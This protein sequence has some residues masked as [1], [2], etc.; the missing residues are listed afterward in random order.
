ME[1]IKIENRDGKETV[2]ARELF[3]F[4]GFDKSQWARW[5]KNNIEDDDFFKQG[6]DWEGF[7]TVLNGNK[8]KDYSITL[9]MAKELS[10]LARNAKG[11][12]ARRYF[13]EVEKKARA[14][15]TAVDETKSKEARKG[16]T[17]MWK[18][19]GII[20]EYGP[21]TNIEYNA[22]GFPKGTKKANM[23]EKQKAFLLISDTWESLRLSME[24]SPLGFS[25]CATSLTHTCLEVR[26]QARRLGLDTPQNLPHNTTPGDPN[27][28][29]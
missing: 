12:E 24:S 25:G 27:Q 4:L 8:T 16:L 22:L 14:Y 23:D 17:A 10:M 18:A 5:A 11:K 15:F 20:N 3:N 28:C 1:L 9:D 2:N 7:D 26:E 13:I 21:L 29:R 6:V 19:H